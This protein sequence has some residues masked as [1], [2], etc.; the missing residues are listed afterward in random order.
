MIW[1]KGGINCKGGDNACINGNQAYT[2]LRTAW[3]K[4]GT[5]DRCSKI[6]RHEN[7]SHYHYYL[8]TDD[9]II[10]SNPR[11]L[12]MDFDPNCKVE[13][14]IYTNIIRKSCFIKVLT[15]HFLTFYT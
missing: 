15:C 1:K 10:D 8:R 3:K 2:D 14:N 13:G 11:L 12:H 5:V 7:G 6:F 9:D 4:C